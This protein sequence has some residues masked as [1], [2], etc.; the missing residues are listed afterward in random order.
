MLDVGDY[1]D[2]AT[3]YAGAV[4]AAK[5][6]PNSRLLTSDS[7]GHPAYGTSACTTGAVDAYLLKGTL[8]K[9]GTVCVGDP[10][11]FA[12]DEE[13]LDA[14]AARQQALHQQ[15]TSSGLVRR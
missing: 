13:E 15:L 11:P 4:S 1:Y 6:M 14:N 10:Q 2:P 5:R 3:N 8:P 7:F 9:A 12:A